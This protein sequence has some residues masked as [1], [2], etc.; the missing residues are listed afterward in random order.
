METRAAR[1]KR[2][3]EQ[4][5]NA[6]RNSIAPETALTGRVSTGGPRLSFL[7]H[8]DKGIIRKDDRV[9]A[10]QTDEKG[11]SLWRLAKV[12][13]ASDPK[14]FSNSDSYLVH[15][16]RQSASADTWLSKDSIL[17]NTEKNRADVV[18]LN[19]DLEKQNPKPFAVRKSGHRSSLSAANGKSGD[20][21]LRS[22]NQKNASQLKLEKIGE[23][24][25]EN[26]DKK[27]NASKSLIPLPRK[28]R[29]P[30]PPANIAS[31]A[32][33]AHPVMN[34]DYTSIR[35]SSMHEKLSDGIL[36]IVPGMR[37]VSHPTFGV[38]GGDIFRVMRTGILLRPE[39]RAPNTFVMVSI[40]KKP[41]V[42][43]AEEFHPR[44]LRILVN[45]QMVQKMFPDGKAPYP[46]IPLEIPASE[47]N[48]VNVLEISWVESTPQELA[49][50]YYVY[51][52]LAKRKSVT[53]VV[54][55]TITNTLTLAECLAHERDSELS[56]DITTG[57]RTV[58][59][60]CPISKQ[61]IGLPVR[62]RYCRH[63]QCFDAGSFISIN[64]GPAARFLCPLCAQVVL[65]HHL[66]VDQFF[67]ELCI[68]TKEHCVELLLDDLG[69]T[70]REFTRKVK[71]PLQVL[72]NIAQSRMPGQNTANDLNESVVCLN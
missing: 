2:L 51:V 67:Q 61:R 8:A 65:P 58:Q 37:V 32:E 41:S 38:D 59:L 24:Q 14:D 49:V 27:A 21:M 63:L 31:A 53:Q 20:S 34:F 26:E 57:S 72:T 50:D 66:V 46:Q 36:R 22:H 55:S 33:P 64:F 10:L 68:F 29:F 5:N 45:E 1:Q 28:Q 52:Y 70:A 7:C 69:I 30:F 12:I 40:C 15:I 56:S 17:T 23:E 48:D 13:D 42:L 11:S 35:I 62:G 47:M 71:V 19:G 60:N 39:Q 25:K 18:K 16:F 3:V 43:P 6:S 44:C 54:E 9:W 4:A